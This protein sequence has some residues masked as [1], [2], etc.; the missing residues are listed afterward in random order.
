MDGWE[1]WSAATVFR[2]LFKLF[3]SIRASGGF[4]RRVRWFQTSKTYQ[5][6]VNPRPHPPLS[7]DSQL[8]MTDQKNEEDMGRPIY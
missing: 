7:S 6:G 8:I 1:R 2:W 3:R 5:L 4:V